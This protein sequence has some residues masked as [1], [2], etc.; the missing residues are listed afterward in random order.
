MSKFQVTL[1]LYVVIGKKKKKRQTINMN[2]YRNWHHYTQ[3][4]VKK[5]YTKMALVQ[6]PN[7]KVDKI[8][9][10]KYILFLPNKRRADLMNYIAVADKFFSDALVHKGIIGDDTVREV[11]KVMAVFGGIDKNK[12]GFI[13]IEVIY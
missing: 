8:K 5:I 9:L 11:S 6:L 3:D 7:V 12:E 13:R 2:N 4:T 10:L 1:P